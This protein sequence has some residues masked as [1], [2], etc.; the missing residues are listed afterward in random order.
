MIEGHPDRL[1]EART[2]VPMYGAEKTFIGVPFRGPT[3]DGQL[4]GKFVPIL[5]QPM[6]LKQAPNRPML[7]SAEAAQSV[8]MRLSISFRHED[9]QG[10]PADFGRVVSKQLLGRRIPRKNA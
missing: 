6:N 1:I 10:L 7:F 3:R 9:G 2:I 4:D 8:G 5:L